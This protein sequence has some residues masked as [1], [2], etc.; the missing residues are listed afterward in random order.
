VGFAFEG[1]LDVAAGRQFMPPI[2]ALATGTVR[3]T[4]RDEA[5]RAVSLGV[6]CGDLRWR[7][8]GGEE[9]LG[10]RK[11]TSDESGNY[12][13]TDMPP[14][15]NV[16]FFGH[17]TRVLG[18]V[19]LPPGGETTV[20]VVVP[21]RKE[22]TLSGRVRMT[23]GEAVSGLRVEAWHDADA[24]NRDIYRES[25]TRVDGA[26]ER[27]GVVGP[28]RMTVYVRDYPIL[29]REVP[30]GSPPFE[31]LLRPDQLPSATIRGRLLDA[32]GAPTRGEVQCGYELGVAS[33]TLDAEGAFAVTT[34]PPGRQRLFVTPEG[35]DLSHHV[36]TIDVSADAERDL[37]TIPLP[38]PSTIEARVTGDG[39]SVV[40]GTVQVAP[41]PSGDWT[42]F[43]IFE[44][45]VSLV[46]PPGRWRLV[47]DLLGARAAAE[48]EVV[49]G[50]T[51]H[52][53]LDLRPTLAARVVLAMTE[54]RP[55][56]LWR[57]NL[58]ATREDGTFAGAF[59]PWRIDGGWSFEIALPADRYH[60]SVTTTDDRK[61]SGLLDLREGGAAVTLR[62]PPR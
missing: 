3:G 57:A 42:E 6:D 26:F 37:G 28:V 53:A 51:N 49:A 18:F 21:L 13:L 1:F 27:P 40:G 4:V 43:R 47:A 11:T 56:F 34:V 19:E 55:D 48:L 38:R 59:R 25:S 54:P 17:P 22:W 20:D 35:W 30:A 58:V 23:T 8:E 60:L 32:T 15:R 2:V 52:V 62:L 7:L 16:L 39:R 29:F 33:V 10:S 5:G 45:S 12:E 41:A 44:G 50:T 31:I 14:G 9:P 61:A 46:V 24:G 36:A